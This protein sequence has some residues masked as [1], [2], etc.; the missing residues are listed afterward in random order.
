M[1]HV[2]LKIQAGRSDEQKIRIAAAITRALVAEAGCGED[3][4]SVSIED[5]ERVDWVGKVYQPDIL[6][7]WG[8]LYKKPGYRPE[9][10]D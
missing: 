6:G 9:G 5:I 4:V 1:P 10:T 7:D 8:R 3:A 2:I